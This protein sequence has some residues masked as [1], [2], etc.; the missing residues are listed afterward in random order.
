MAALARALAF[1]KRSGT[2][3]GTATDPG[4]L[5]CRAHTPHGSRK[6]AALENINIELSCCVTCY[7]PMMHK[8]TFVWETA[9]GLTLCTL[10]ASRSRAC[11]H[12]F[13]RVSPIQ[14]SAWV[15]P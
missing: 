8:V 7:S 4:S 10:T 13:L 5:I 12:S 9:P 3:V 11:T 15:V 14:A 2:S 6:R 1:R